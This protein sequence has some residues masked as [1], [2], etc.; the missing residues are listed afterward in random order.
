MLTYIR[1][2]CGPNRS[3]EN[4]SLHEILSFEPTIIGSTSLSCESWAGQ[5]GR[6][7][8]HCLTFPLLPPALT[9][10][11]SAGQSLSPP[12]LSLVESTNNNH[13]T[14][15]VVLADHNC[16]PQWNILGTQTFLSEQSYAN[17]YYIYRII[18]FLQYYY[19]WYAHK[20]TNNS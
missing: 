9:L 5:D 6:F 3:I 7:H 17:D 12:S 8:F 14:G 1:S 10:D 4:I 20:F 13:R 16:R 18:S 11:Q 19:Y 15:D 2:K